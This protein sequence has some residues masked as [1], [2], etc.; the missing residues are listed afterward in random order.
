MGVEVGGRGT[1]GTT[2]EAPLAWVVSKAS[3]SGVF[4]SSTIPL[5]VLVASWLVLV[6]AG[7]GR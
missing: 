5:G 1:T 7:S 3:R 6:W 4:S 2:G